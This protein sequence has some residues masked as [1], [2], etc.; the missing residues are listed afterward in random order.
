MIE[1]VNFPAFKSIGLEDRDIIQERLWRYQPET[2][3]LTFTNLF[4]WRA[5]YEVRWSL[6]QDWLL[7]VFGRPGHSLYALPPVGPSSR[8]EV[9][10]HL[11]RWMKEEGASEPRIERADQRLVTELADT[12]DFQVEPT[13]EHFDY[14]YRRQDLIQLAGRKYHAKRNYINTFRRTYQFDYEDLT[15]N[16]V[17]A[18]LELA[19]RWCQMHRC[20]ADMSLAGEWTAVSEALTNFGALKIK[21]GVIK[22]NGEVQAFTLGELLN[23]Q[24]A[25]VHIEKADP[26]IRGL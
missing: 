19:D 26:E 11:L 15:S 4:I 24:T 16:H 23:S 22:L 20:E 8:Q 13:R 2:S 6:H 3:E 9:S 18:C 25:V 5:Y 10:R 7:I 14:V 12:S 21:G 1:L 17:P